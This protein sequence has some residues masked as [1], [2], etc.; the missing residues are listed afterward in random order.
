MLQLAMI[1]R[2]RYYKEIVRQAQD[3]D[4]LQ[5]FADKVLAGIDNIDLKSYEF[6]R[7]PDLS[8]KLD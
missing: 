1:K 2:D 6:Q 8:I 4:A 5:A 7:D 3:K